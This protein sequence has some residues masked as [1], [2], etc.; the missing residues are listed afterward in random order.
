MRLLKTEHA[1][2][3]AKIAA[4]KRQEKEHE[5]RKRERKKKKKRKG[6]DLENLLKII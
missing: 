4:R 5:E 6:K 1:A 2:F 3:P